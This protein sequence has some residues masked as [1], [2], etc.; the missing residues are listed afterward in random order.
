MKALVATG[1]EIL[2]GLADVPEPVAAADAAL[3]R[4]EAFSVNRGEILALTGVY[5]TPT[6]PGVVPGQDVVGRVVVAAADGSGPAVGARVVAHAAGGGWAELVA[7]ATDA[8]TELPDAV[9]NEVAAALPLAGLTALRLLRHI[10]APRG[11][12]VLLTGASGGVGH[13]LVELLTAAGASVTA[14]VADAERGSRLAEFG[15]RVITDIAADTDRYDVIMES[16]GGEV[17]SEAIRKLEPGGLV[18][19]FGQASLQP[20]RLDFF[21]LM[22][23]TP[24]TLKHF[25]HWVA[26]TTDAEDLRTLVELVAADRLHPELGRVADWTATAETLTDLNRRRIRG[27]AV[28]T[29]EAR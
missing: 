13:Y 12:R 9:P 24:F 6:A 22:S 14:V 10:D 5:G 18:L 29:I 20:V 4:V 7:V 17:F 15:A 19:W 3:I 1:N 21:E 11:A 16:V 27:N 2:V 8:L 25:P 26:D 23:A 28:L